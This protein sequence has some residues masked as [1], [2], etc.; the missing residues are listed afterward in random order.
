[1]KLTRT[2]VTADRAAYAAAGYDLPT[3]DYET[4]QRNTLERPVWIHF[5]AGNLFRAFQAK[6][7]R[8]HV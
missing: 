7:G 6:I 5:G 3:F 8:A 4:I 1:M 2:G